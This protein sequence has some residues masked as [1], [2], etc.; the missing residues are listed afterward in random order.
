MFYGCTSLT[1]V[2]AL[3]ANSFATGSYSYM[4][5]GCTSLG[6]YTAQS[7]SHQYV[8]RIP[9]AG[10]SN[11]SFTYTLMFYNIKSDSTAPN[12]VAITSG[13]SVTYYVENEPVS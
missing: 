10:V 2:P 1:K 13:S 6:V 7:D 8:F 9:V 5:Q 3:P 4:F 12:N 11:Y